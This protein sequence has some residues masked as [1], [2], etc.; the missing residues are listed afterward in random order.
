MAWGIVSIGD[1]P[2]GPW[3]SLVQGFLENQGIPAHADGI[4][5]QAWNFPTV[6]LMGVRVEV[7]AEHAE[8]ARAL[9][10]AA[11]DRTRARLLVERT[12]F[13]A[14]REAPPLPDTWEEPTEPEPQ[15]DLEALEAAVPE[16]IETPHEPPHSPD[17]QHAERAYRCGVFGLW[18]PAF[19][20]AALALMLR[21]RAPVETSSLSPRGHRLRRAT[22]AALCIGSVQ[23]A[24]RWFLMERSEGGIDWWWWVW[25]TL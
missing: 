25:L 4:C 5:T 22:F 24:G 1:F 6:P 23:L 2:G 20:F 3:A 13:D 11:E 18:I 7:R 8:R 16:P 17:D 21:E 19:L 12:W 9:V 15:D 10:T 14:P